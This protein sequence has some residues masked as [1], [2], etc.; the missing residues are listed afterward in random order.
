M[1]LALSGAAQTLD[2]TG[3]ATTLGL[4][5]RID[6]RARLIATLL[7][8]CVVVASHWIPTLL[9]ALAASCTAMVFAQL[10]IAS[11][12][13]RMAAMDS[14]IIFILILLPFTMPGEAMFTVF[15]FP[16]SWEGLWRAVEIGLKANAVVLMLMA[17]VGTMEAV[18]LGHALH[19]LKVPERL[20]HLLLFTVRYI[21][22]LY[23]EHVRLKQAMKARGFKARNS[24]HTYRSYGYLLG[25]MLVRAMERSERILDAMKCRGF[26][27]RIPLLGRYEYTKR[28]TVFAALMGALLMILIGTEIYHAV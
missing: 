1:V 3:R 21:E 23:E 15:G 24:L 12:L 7:F 2:S 22:V 14:F 28:D 13:K 16:A 6:P 8:A 10:P 26:T 18:T 27:G 11:T 25:M 9:I 17:L 5:G 4:L 19:H 20:V